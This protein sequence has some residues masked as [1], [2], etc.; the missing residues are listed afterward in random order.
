MEGGQRRVEGEGAGT[1][2]CRSRRAVASRPAAVTNNVSNRRKVASSIQVYREHCHEGVKA[3]PG[4]L[5]ETSARTTNC[6]T[7][8]GESRGPRYPGDLL[9]LLQQHRAPAD[10]RLD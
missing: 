8:K 9:L 6:L 2:G 1:A 4:N 5:I 10:V 3:P 7:R